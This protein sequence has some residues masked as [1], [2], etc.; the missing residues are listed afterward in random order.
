MT[1]PN[2][3]AQLSLPVQ[4]A[5]EVAAVTASW[6]KKLT[7]PNPFQINNAAV[8]GRFHMQH[9]AAQYAPKRAEQVQALRQ[10]LPTILLNVIVRGKLDEAAFARI[11]T[12]NLGRMFPAGATVCTLPRETPSGESTELHT[13]T[14][15][16]LHATFGNLYM[17]ELLRVMVGE[18]FWT[19]VPAY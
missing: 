12:Q 1:S 6:G 15:G 10:I 4:T 17:I 7:H 5:A 14:W 3:T 11:I 8:V 19:G 9:G 2:T 18:A 13:E 16:A